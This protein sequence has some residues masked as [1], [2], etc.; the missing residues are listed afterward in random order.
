MDC[1]LCQLYM[2]D[3]SWKF[4]R[5]R[6]G[7]LELRLLDQGPSFLAACRD[8]NRG[9]HKGTPE[10]PRT[11][12]PE[13]EQCYEHYLECVAVGQFPDEPVVRRNAAVIRGVIDAVERD[14]EVEF[15]KTLIEL[16]MIK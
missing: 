6:R 8:P 10:N 1:D 7:E 14:R 11:L 9:C 2:V 16:V 4:E 13:N 15:Q 12:S 5:D 3:D